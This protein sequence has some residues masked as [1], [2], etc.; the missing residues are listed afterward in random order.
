MKDIKIDAPHMKVQYIIEFRFQ[1]KA[2]YEMKKIIY[3]LDRRF[4]LRHTIKKRPIPH[5]TIVAP[6]Y[7]KN[8][9]RLV[10]DFNN[11]CKILPLINFKI[12]GYGSFDK[13]KVIYI[14]IIPSKELI[15]FRKDLIHQIKNYSALEDYDQEEFYK[16]HATLAMKLSNEQFRD[17]K[18]DVLKKD[19]VHKNYSMVRATLIKG[20]KILYEYDFLLRKLLNRKQSKN[21][22]IY[23]KTLSKLKTSSHREIVKNLGFLSKLKRFFL[24]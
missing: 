22:I 12:G 7:T 6:F 13:S 11:I 15:Q 9:K 10:N 8:Q 1:G 14:N 21:K 16:P 18:R 19:R 3:D 20:N 5:V 4:N 17:L 2:K 24:R 23:S